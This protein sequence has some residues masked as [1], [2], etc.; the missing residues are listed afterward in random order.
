MPYP[1]PPGPRIAYDLDGTAVFVT[2]WTGAIS[3]VDVHKDAVKAMN[4]DSTAH[5]V[6]S[7]F[8]LNSTPQTT[9]MWNNSPYELSYVALVFPSP[10]RLYGALVHMWSYYYYSGVS[11]WQVC[12][13]ISG[14]V[15]TTN[16]VDGTWVD[17][18][19][20]AQAIPQATPLSNAV[21]GVQVDVE[22]VR[23]LNVVSQALNDLY[24]RPRASSPSAEGYVEVAGSATRNLRGLRI[25]PYG[26]NGT[27]LV[28]G[29]GIYSSPMKLNLHLYGAPDVGAIEDRLALW[30]PDLDAA[31]PT[32]WLDW[33]DV[34]L[35]TSADKTFRVRNH[36]VTKTAS[37]VLVQAVAGYSDSTPSAAGM[38]TFS[39]DGLTWTSSVEISALSPGTS[40]A[41]IRVRRVVPANAMLSN[42]S[43]RISAAAASWS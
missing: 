39:L 6:F 19:V 2:K 38:L 12:P 10:I 34:P 1:A 18:T 36:S 32:G 43:P 11:L 40:S 42:W 9:H 35:S 37:Q 3:M 20:N 25:R 27:G 24:R 30:R 26:S 21:L 29:T 17:I 31:L 15:D 14:S 5:A 33:G 16:G 7:V 4:S 41:V 22:G 28:L 23:T 13:A 8:D